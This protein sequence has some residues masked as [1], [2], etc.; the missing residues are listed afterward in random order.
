MTLVITAERR[1]DRTPDGRIWTP[2]TAAYS[3]W[4]RYLDVFD[5]VRV[6]ARVR[7][8]SSADPGAQRADGPGVTFSPV[9]F[10]HGPA[11]YVIC[12]RAIG[13]AIREAMTPD[14]VAGSMFNRFMVIGTS[15]PADAAT[16]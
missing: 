7:E 9:P 13:R 15:T 4:Q 1:F 16:K 6:V 8:V 12:Y 11:Q 14:A 10:F 5:Q 2:S 3:F